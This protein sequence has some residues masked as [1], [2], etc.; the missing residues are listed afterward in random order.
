MLAMRRAKLELEDAGIFGVAS[1][2]VSGTST[3][4]T[5]MGIRSIISPFVT[6]MGTTATYLSFLTA[7]EFTFRYGSPQKLLI[8][9]PLFKTAL[10]YW[11][12]NKQL[13]K[14]D[15][16]LFGVSLKK[17]ITSNGTW[18][19][20]NNFNFG[21]F[22]ASTNYSFEALGIDLPSIEFC[23]LSENGFN[24]DTHLITNYN[25]TNPKIIYDLVLTIAGWRCRHPARH[26]RF[27]N[28]QAFS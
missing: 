3:R 13:V 16:D 28:L 18:L 11:A 21:D 27:T 12:A 26:A 14:P 23:P 4:L 20:A 7:N 8:A 9:S 6:D 10:D 2:S 19:L 5:S 15:I 25:T 17:F 1:S 24:N 22:G